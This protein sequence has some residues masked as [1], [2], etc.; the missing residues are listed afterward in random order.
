MIWLLA[1]FS[2]F[3]MALLI[4][5]IR[6]RH[7][8]IGGMLVAAALPALIISL[9][10]K[11]GEGLEFPYLFLGTVFALDGTRAVL[12]FFTS[13]LWLLAGWFAGSY[14]AKDEFRVRFDVF[15]LLSMAGNFGLILAADIVS[16][17]GFFV[18]MTFASFGL[19]VH[20]WTAEARRAGHVYLVLAVFGEILLLASIFLAVATADSILVKELGPAVAE[21]P[22][23]NVI[24]GLALAGF[25]VKAGVVPLYFWLP[26]AHPVAPTPASAVLSGAMIKAGIVGWLH[27][28]PL[29]V[30]DLAGWGNVV[31]SLGFLATFGAVVI[32]LGQ[33]NPK[34]I[35]AY[36][37][38][39]Q[40]GLMTV[41]VGLGMGS[42]LSWNL[43]GLPVLLLL[44][45]NH[46]LAK[47][48]L[49]LGT[50][51][52][53]H[54]V[55]S[56]VWVIAGLSVAALAIAG[57]PLTGGAQAKY[58]I[59][60]LV[61]QTEGPWRSL[62]PW[63]LSLSS[64]GTTLLLIR[65]LRVLYRDNPPHRPGTFRGE[66]VPWAILVGA[67]V[68]VPVLAIRFFA[69]PLPEMT[70]SVAAIG[71]GFWPVGLAGLIY[72]LAHQ[73]RYWRLWEGRIPP[74]DLLVPLE[75]LVHC[76]LQY[77][78]QRIV[79][80]WENDVLNIARL[81][82]RIIAFEAAKEGVGRLERAMGSWS[83]VG[84]MFLLILLLLTVF[85]VL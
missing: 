82:D 57:F 67:V 53:V 44:A 81:A 1:L 85:V 42:A 54:A 22:H 75:R 25:G 26:L 70:L 45:L 18:L 58:G 30:V 13:L 28:V 51:V 4:P 29:G 2:P 80:K 50:G 8:T 38:V 66:V 48:A 49:F 41:V 32:G 73:Q 52:F 46:S 71:G 3:L 77:R 72:L 19:V 39:S 23:R 33:T 11:Q 84:L 10:G 17:Y 55:R 20:T 34:T 78:G 9:V 36:S 64:L 62:L 79:E 6:P 27:I 83:V 14:Q 76:L 43:V 15:F 31:V 56:R 47:G 65:F 59:L 5:A 24:I 16:F 40:I 63:A 37:S 7:A 12:L 61:S 68:V 60:K 21:A 69:L 35:L 74:G